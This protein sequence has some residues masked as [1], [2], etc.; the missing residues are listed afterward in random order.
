MQDG[1]GPGGP[2][3]HRRTDP[4]EMESMMKRRKTRRRAKRRQPAGAVLSVAVLLIAAAAAV[5]FVKPGGVSKA[6]KELRMAGIEKMDAGDFS[7]AMAEFEAA[8]QTAKKNPG[9]FEID[10]LKYRAEAEYKLED[11]LA[12]AHTYETLLQ[13]DEERPEYLYR[14]ALMKAMVGDIDGAVQAYQTG[15]QLEQE[16]G[17]Q[18]GKKDK[19]ADEA[20][21]ADGEAADAQEGAGG[22]DG[23][24][25]ELFGQ[26]DALAAVARACLDAQR[27]EDAVALYEDAIRN[28][29][30][31]PSVF[32]SLGLIYLEEERYEGALGFFEQAVQM[33]DEHG[34]ALSPR[35][36]LAVREAC[37]NQA[38]TYERLGQFQT[39]LQYFQA[40]VAQYGADEAAQ[41]EI[42]FLQTR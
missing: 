23:Q 5:F 3:Q 36:A 38:V 34:G 21:G 24:Q 31:D 26:A 17:E 15:Y 33:E 16:T 8:L 11:Y 12:A 25:T 4:P 19:P 29:T 41:K 30:T 18:S 28:G 20:K 6:R 32:N 35:E 42:T 13:V 40:Y 10:V 37:F 1:H 27:G 14:M 39:A 22:A 9:A 7:G 2:G